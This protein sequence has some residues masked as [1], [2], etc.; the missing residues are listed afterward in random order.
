MHP[1][2]VL[3]TAFS[4]W[5]LYDAMQRRV[6]AYW[7]C[8]ICVPMGEF[9]Y[10]FAVK[11]HDFDL[12][13]LRLRSRRPSLDVARYRLEQN[14]CVANQ[15]DLSEALYASGELEEAT[16]LCEAAV[17]RDATYKHAHY[18][19]GRCLLRQ[20]RLAEAGACFRRVVE[21]D[22]A[23]EDYGAWTDLA[24]VLKQQGRGDEAIGELRK[25]EAASPRIA[26][27][28]ALCRQLRDAGRVEEAHRT[29]DAALRDLAHAPRH[30]KRLAKPHLRE[31]RGLLAELAKSARCA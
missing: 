15:M 8:I 4:L 22:R 21:L 17:R 19:L 18:G 6:P 7:F 1:F 25:L 5:M 12:P 20:D 26:H 2:Y 23:Y 16:A 31:A 30:A 14:P 9:A 27:S 24:E 3:S 29:L 10:F 13:S 28:V 11:I